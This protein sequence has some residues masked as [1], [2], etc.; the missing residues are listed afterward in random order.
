[1]FLFSL[2]LTEA[3]VATC[4][5]VSEEEKAK[6][7]HISYCSKPLEL[8]IPLAEIIF[9]SATGET[10]EDFY[11]YD[12]TL[13]MPG[14][15]GSSFHEEWTE[16]QMFI[17]NNCWVAPTFGIVRLV[18]DHAPIDDSYKSVY[19]DAA[20]D[21]LTFDVSTN[22]CGAPPPSELNYQLFS[23]YD[24][25]NF[26]FKSTNSG[27]IS[28]YGDAQDGDGSF[29]IACNL[30]DY[31]AADGWKFYNISIGRDCN[32]LSEKK[33][34]K[35][36]VFKIKS[37]DGSLLG[38]PTYIDELRIITEPVYEE[39]SYFVYTGKPTN[40]ISVELQVEGIDT[41]DQSFWIENLNSNVARWDTGKKKVIVD[42]NGSFVIHYSSS[43]GLTLTPSTGNVEN[44]ARVL[45]QPSDNC[46]ALVEYMVYT[47]EAARERYANLI[48]SH[49]AFGGVIFSAFSIVNSQLSG[50]SKSGTNG[51]N[52]PEL[53]LKA[54]QDEFGADNV[55]FQPAG[56]LG[57]AWSGRDTFPYSRL[58]D[59]E[60]VFFFDDSVFTNA[61]NM[62]DR[63]LNRFKQY[64][65]STGLTIESDSPRLADD[66]TILFPDGKRL[67]YDPGVSQY[68][69]LG[70]EF[71][72]LNIVFGRGNYFGNDDALAKFA[73]KLDGI[74]R[75]E[76]VVDLVQ[77]YAYQT[78]K[79]NE[80]S[81]MDY[82]VPMGTEVET[83]AKAYKELSLASKIRGD[84][85]EIQN[86]LLENYDYWQNIFEIQYRETDT[87]SPDTYQAFKNKFDVIWENF[88][89]EGQKLESLIGG[90]L[91]IVE[92]NGHKIYILKNEIQ[93]IE[94]YIMLKNQ[95]ISVI[96]SQI[97]SLKTQDNIFNLLEDY[98]K[99]LN[100]AIDKKDIPK[101]NELQQ[102]ILQLELLIPEEI[103]LK[104]EIIQAI[105]SN[106]IVLTTAIASNAELTSD[107]EFKLKDANIFTKDTVFLGR[108]ELGDDL[109]N[110]KT[111]LEN[112]GFAPSAESVEDHKLVKNIF[113]DTSE[114]LESTVEAPAQKVPTDGLN[115][116]RNS[117]V[118]DEISEEAINP[119]NYVIKRYGGFI[120]AGGLTAIFAVGP[121]LRE[122]GNKHQNSMIV[123]AADIIQAGGYVAVLSVFINNIFAYG[124]LKG[125]IYT[126]VLFVDPINILS[127]GAGGVVIDI[128]GCFIF[129]IATILVNIVVCYF[130]DPGSSVCQGCSPNL[131]YGKA[132]LKLEKN[133]VGNGETI[134]FT[135]YG[136]N[137]CE[138]YL[139]GLR[140]PYS[141]FVK[142][143]GSLGPYVK[144]CIPF[145]NCCGN[146]TLTVSLNP[147]NYQVEGGVQA[148]SGDYSIIAT[149]DSQTLTVCPAGQIGDESENKCV[150]CN[151]KKETSG[152][153]EADCGASPECDDKSSSYR[154][155]YPD[156]QVPKISNAGPVSANQMRSC[157]GAKGECVWQVM[158]DSFIDRVS[159]NGMSDY[160]TVMSNQN[161][162]VVVEVRNTG[163]Y[164]QD[165]WYVGV[166]FWNVSDFIDPW[167]TR[168]GN[169]RVNT[170]YNGRDNIGGCDP[171]P[172]PIN[173][174]E[175]GNCPANSK[176]ELVSE[177]NPDPAHN[178]DPGETITLKCQVPAS[179]YG[180]IQ[181]NER[182]M[183]WVHE[184]D[185]GQDADN[186]GNVGYWWNDALS[187]SY[188]PGIDSYIGG[189][190]ALTRVKVADP[191]D[192][193]K[194]GTVDIF[195][196]VI[197]AAAFG[198]SSGDTNYKLISDVN[199]D[200]WVNIFDIVAVALNYG[201][202]Y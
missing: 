90:N 54:A 141:F 118:F 101:L 181:G 163:E 102:K 6:W 53:L 149:S 68:L 50:A 16:D 170:F 137:H 196:I 70:S 3:R 100:K 113:H 132:Q 76:V 139:L 194:D 41:N 5:A 12:F 38:G 134:D 175:G 82:P 146:C 159:V 173:A 156:N 61:E 92:I 13:E 15:E 45:K 94:I 52:I 40:S 63:I 125:I 32:F 185:L 47:Q 80:W 198:S 110:I 56:S 64:A 97:T 26:W 151:G 142:Q 4:Q 155:G 22:A 187:R 73:T 119:K 103:E 167:N 191:S 62:E 66:L 78:A 153:C 158:F 67:I 150:T 128:S 104:G 180:P 120:L 7:P 2:Q 152:T 81:N 154:V 193:N 49:E 197:V 84:P 21:G 69:S 99:E 133:I 124:V 11:G 165:W 144:S 122:Y 96:D 168:D 83:P 59:L 190:P 43:N 27:P 176:C 44:D 166:E 161:I 172:D 114:K 140:V 37:Y 85:I 77:E 160:T 10:L 39:N 136:M 42:G 186:D 148:A 33:T 98:N 179:F 18:D 109:G 200:G 65:E 169:G 177:S 19:G 23:I 188:R 57:F 105:D 74:T 199:Q 129:I 116:A 126:I 1:M 178:F 182:I 123:L 201:K 117:D 55:V 34:I 192:I 60:F 138:E 48:A 112:K 17:N 157:Y 174:P 20:G 89:I 202:T 25:V 51:I 95:D 130:L 88:A 171:D 107:L 111:N 189:G 29:E 30:G 86:L 14:E 46:A 115:K 127:A 121:L 91:L 72:D 87:I 75:G 24:R 147:G 28:F 143:P 131:A 195:D 71:K 108:L 8:E 79:A 184:R 35:K 58:G 93:D 36:I 145:G 106:K 31:N 164:Q 9:D 135:V 162:K 183:F